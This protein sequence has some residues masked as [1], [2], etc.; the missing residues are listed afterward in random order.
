MQYI[1]YHSKMLMWCDFLT[2]LLTENEYNESHQTSIFWQICT[3]LRLEACLHRDRVTLYKVCQK[4]GNRTS[5]PIIC[6]L[7]GVWTI[8]FHIRKDQAFSYWMICFSCQVEKKYACTR[9]IKNV[10]Q[11]CIFSPLCL[12]KTMH[13]KRKS[14]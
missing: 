9:P 5:R 2:Y 8:G 10:S 14:N 4:K 12:I 7:L 13:N 1:A 3:S 6:E 11:N